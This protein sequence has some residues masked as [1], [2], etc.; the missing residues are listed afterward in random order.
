GGA[1]LGYL[2]VGRVQ[3]HGAAGAVL[4]AAGYV[5]D[6]GKIDTQQRRQAFQEAYLAHHVVGHV[7]PGGIGGEGD[8]RAGAR[9]VGLAAVHRVFG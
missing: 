4:Q 6:S 5:V 2:V 3:G 1:Q 9:K 8:E 7:L